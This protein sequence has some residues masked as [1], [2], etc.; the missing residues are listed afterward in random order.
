MTRFLIAGCLALTA[1]GCSIQGKWTAQGEGPEGSPCVMNS[2]EF[3]ADNSFSAD[4]NVEGRPMQMSG[5]Y[6][7]DALM[8]KLKLE[9][10]GGKTREYGTSLSM[11]GDTLTMKSTEGEKTFSQDFNRDD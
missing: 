11:D 10:E 9:M 8:C 3:K 4:A 7:Y 5:T 2:M 6:S 1:T